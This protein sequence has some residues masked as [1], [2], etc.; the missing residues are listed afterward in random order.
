MEQ[1]KPLCSVGG[2]VNGCSHCGKHNGVS[3]K[4]RLELSYDPVTP[5]LCIYL[6]YT[7]PVISRGIYTPM[8][9]VALFIIAKIWKQPKCSLMKEWIKN[10]YHT[11]KYYSSTKKNRISP[12]AM[13]WVDLRWCKS[14]QWLH[15]IWLTSVEWEADWLG[16][17]TKSLSEKSFWELFCQIS[18]NKLREHLNSE[19][20]TV[21]KLYFN[22]KWKA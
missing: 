15:L 16:A 18:Q 21:W 9:I 13:T 5:F 1:R 7:K 2:N 17:A 10:M 8:F 20:F 22:K 19:D 12:F 11:M 4:L 3:S 14:D 6:K